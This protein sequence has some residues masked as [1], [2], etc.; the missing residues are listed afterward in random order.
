[1]MRYLFQDQA[2]NKNT[3]N[4]KSSSTLFVTGD[5][6]VSKVFLQTNCVLLNHWFIACLGV[7]GINGFFM[8]LANIQSSAINY[9][10]YILLTAYI[11]FAPAL[12]KPPDRQ[13]VIAHIIFL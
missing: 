3:R 5:F 12:K 1:M 6:N 10:N 7:M 9:T 13:V 2:E 11:W 8:W 4:I